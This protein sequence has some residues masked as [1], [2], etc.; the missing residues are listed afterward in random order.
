MRLFER[1]QRLIELAASLL[2]LTE[3]VPCLREIGAQSERG[4]QR[5]TC[6]ACVAAAEPNAPDVV[7]RLGVNRSAG[8]NAQK[9][10]ESIVFPVDRQQRN[11]Q[12]VSKLRRIV[13]RCEDGAQ[14]LHGERRISRGECEHS[15]VVK[16]SG[17]SR[18]GFQGCRVERGGSRNLARLMRAQRRAKPSLDGPA[19][20]SGRRS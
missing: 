17:M 11:S 9:L 3:A 7:L 19:F 15:A 18:I 1:R 12:V 16:G 4:P 13:S 20:G 6:S 8:W 2:E 14:S 10:A 5:L